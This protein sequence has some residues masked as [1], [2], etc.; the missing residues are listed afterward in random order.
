MPAHTPHL[1]FDLA[2]REL[3]MTRFDGLA[4]LSCFL[5]FA[6][7]TTHCFG[8]DETQ[9]PP[10]HYEV[11]LEDQ[12]VIVQEGE[13]AELP[14]MFTNP[15]VTIT[16]R[17]NRVFSYHGVEFKYPRT[18][19]F[20]ANVS[21]PDVKNWKLSSKHFNVSL[22]V[23][24]S[25]LTTD[26]YA[27]AMSRLFGLDPAHIANEKVELT[28]GAETLHGTSLLI[29]LNTRVSRLNLASTLALDV[30]QL[31][32]HGNLSTFLVFQDTFNKAGNHSKEYLD[33]IA[34]MKTSFVLTPLNPD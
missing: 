22:F 16:P 32:S 5:C 20:E 19:V 13:T 12:S 23:T 28:L 3:L 30:Y 24:P 15:K 4:R 1:G 33:T 2:I 27:S 18:F 9:E 34:A 29:D 11:K 6:F 31:P 17:Q 7:G 10:L 26:Q 14:G 8:E 25:G 21:K